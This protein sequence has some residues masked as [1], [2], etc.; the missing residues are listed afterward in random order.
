M[1]QGGQHCA[2]WRGPVIPQH[3]LAT[4]PAQQMPRMPWGGPPAHVLAH[5]SAL[6]QNWRPA[7]RMRGSIA[8]PLVVGQG[9]L[10]SAPRGNPFVDPAH[11]VQYQMRVPPSVN[12]PPFPRGPRG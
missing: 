11:A 9:V 10:G 6:Q 3:Q 12:L 2:L 4:N 1:N 8:N 7:P 5:A